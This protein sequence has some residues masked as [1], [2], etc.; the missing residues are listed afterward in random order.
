MD[1]TTNAP[2]SVPNNEPDKQQHA[3]APKPRR[4]WPRRVAASLL[5]ALIALVALG[6]ALLATDWGTRTLWRTARHFVPGLSGDISGSLTRGLNLRNLV[7]DAAGTH[8]AID[9]ISGAWHIV[10]APRG[11]VIENLDA[12]TVDLTL[13]PSKNDNSKT[14]LPQQI[15]LPLRLQLDS[16][17]ISRLRLHDAGK[18][19]EFTDIKLAASSDTVHHRAQASVDTPWG[20]VASTLQL[21]GSARPFPLTGTINYHGDWDH[22][23]Y[24]ADAKLSGSLENLGIALDAAGGALDAHATIAATPFAPLPFRSAKLALDHLD[25]RR[26]APAAPQSDLQIRADLAPVGNAPPQDLAQ[27]SVAGPLTVR[28]AIPG[29]I[30]QSRLPLAS[31]DAQLSL[32]AERQQLS[33]LVAKLAGGATLEGEGELRKDGSG[34]AVLRARDLDLHAIDAAVRPTRLNG[35]IELAMAN[36]EQQVRV[37]LK[38]GPLALAAEA[39]IDAQQILLKRAQLRAGDARLDVSGSL[40]RDERASYAVKAKLASLDP[41]RFLETVAPP[42]KQGKKAPRIPRADINMD[43]EAEGAMK[44]E[45]GAKLRFTIH[46]SSYENL[47]MSG[48]G[49]LQLQG[50][51]IPAAD[52]RLLVAGNRVNLNGGFGAP[53]KTLAFDIDAPALDRLGFGLAGLLRAQGTATGSIERPQVQ[54]NLQAERLALGELGVAHLAG[55]IDMRGVPGEDPNAHIDVD[56]NGRALHAANVLLNDFSARING[57]YARHD[58]ALAANGKL[59]GQPLQAV[60]AAQGA[61]R[62]QPNGMAWEGKLSKLEN[63]GV[64]QATLHSPLALLAEPGHVRLGATRLDVEGARIE[65]ANADVAVDGPIR[66]KGSLANLDIAR[67]LALAQRFTGKPLPVKSDLVLDGEWDFALGDSASGGFGI[68]R[69]SGDVQLPVGSGTS[70][71]GLQ[72]LQ[73]AGTMAGNA[74]ALNLDAG[75]A[76]YGTVRGEGRIGLVPGAGRLDINDSSTLSGRVVATLPKLA[77]LA[78]LTGPRIALNGSVRLDLSAAGTVGQPLVSGE[79]FGD[80]LA[81]TL[82]DQGVRLHDGIARI[83]IRDNIAEL[84]E[85][86]FHGGDGTLRATGRVPLDASSPDMAATIVA[87]HLQLLA[88]PSAQLTVSG[89]ASVA[90]LNDQLRVNGRFTVDRGLFNLPEKSAPKLS[91]DVVVYRAGDKPDKPPP[92]GQEGAGQRAASPFSPYVDV[93]VDMGNDFWFRGAGANLRLAGTLSIRSAPNETLQAIGTV[94]IAEGNYKAF[95]AELA[96]E[97]GIINFQGSL[98]NPNINIL[99]MRRNQD[100]AAGVQVTGTVN[101]PRVT[102]V[103]EPN[104]ADEEKL[105]WLVFGH[106][107]SSAGTGADTAARGAALGLLNKLG[108]DKLAKGFGL[109]QLSIGTSEYGVAGEQVVSLG[110]NISDRLAIGYE[111][112][113]AGASGVVR[114][115]WR[116]GRFWSVVL[117][118]G[119]IGGL[120][121]NYSRRFDQLGD[122][123]RTR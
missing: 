97:R 17:H 30:D 120:D 31:L 94:R 63:R 12:G 104:V 67:M 20:T 19:T 55:K 111:Q 89:Q 83:S 57:S 45:L 47:P 86:V 66:S 50:K 8:I 102:L 73:L 69:R 5:L 16:A 14:Q 33:A 62:Q 100:V 65:L 70:P 114:L 82:Y 80:D 53:G 105:S 6:Y 40:G 2:D 27:L 78:A 11:L 41:A 106:G 34:S 23:R 85:V 119:Q 52:V 84:K 39:N 96:I 43:L 93:Q 32:N 95:G 75:T 3:K 25:V 58:I 22:E 108:G 116:I 10:R 9:R 18:T 117:R 123:E 72:S 59:A 4:R 15:R 7:Y 77:N 46:D 56:V 109:D 71:L 90:N 91:D 92:R 74:L 36:G 48:D 60:L 21:D 115:T 81:L 107:G 118:G 88:D 64:P 61:L 121:L 35:P 112:S 28:N 110:K 79:V 42:Q 101:D 99:A 76:R 26:F 54:A 1:D 51:A 122:L 87:D 98:T 49:T 44:P 113:L 24:V 13:P 68:T 37:D 38:G 29:R 103:S